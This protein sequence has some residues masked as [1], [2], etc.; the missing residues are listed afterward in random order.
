MTFKYREGLGKIIK[1]DTVLQTIPDALE[2]E[3]PEEALKSSE[4]FGGLLHEYIHYIQNFTQ[5]FPLF[6]CERVLDQGIIQ[7]IRP[8][9]DQ[10]A[11]HF[12]FEGKA[13]FDKI[14]ES[15]FREDLFFYVEPIKKKIPLTYN[16]LSEN[17]VYLF[18][19]PYRIGLRPWKY[20][21]IAKEVRLSAS[22]SQYS[23]PLVIEYS[24]MNL[25]M[26]SRFLEL[27]KLAGYGDY[28]AKLDYKD[29][30]SF[31][32][33]YQAGEKLIKLYNDPRFYLA[34]HK[35]RLIDLVKKG[36]QLRETYPRLLTDL[37]LSSPIEKM[38]KLKDISKVLG[39]PIE[40]SMPLQALNER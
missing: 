13:D 11:P 36:R 4:N 8:T 29:A 7:S 1:P 27:Y 31:E 25:N 39:F 22:A 14:E 12:A 38:I 40:C 35:S 26:E 3:T 21:Y 16:G 33:F 28:L 23:L 34:D 18:E 15:A 9:P 20:E 32:E 10:F 6:L 2:F 5:T 37:I 30:Y 19:R 17:Q 24:L